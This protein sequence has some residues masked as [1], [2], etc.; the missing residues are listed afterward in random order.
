MLTSNDYQYIEQCSNGLYIVGNP[1]RD[2]QFLK[3]GVIDD[4]GQTIIPLSFISIS[5]EIGRYF[6]VRRLSDDK[7][8]MLD[9]NGNIVI[10]YGQY[11]FLWPF[12]GSYIKVRQ[13]RFYGLLDTD[14]N[15][16]LPCKY[17]D[18]F[19][20]LKRKDGDRGN[21]YGV[22]ENRTDK[23]TFLDNVNLSPVP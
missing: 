13:N 23:W 9:M 11:S 7:T 1:L 6:R 3:Y 14:L 18:M 15:I 8:A 19:S 5:E 4:K 10:D 12:Y 17:S 22:K 20:C 16:A 2:G 21:C